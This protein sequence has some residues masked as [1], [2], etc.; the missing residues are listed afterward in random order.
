M[1][2][3]QEMED[4]MVARDQVEVSSCQLVVW[5]ELEEHALSLL[6][7]HISIASPVNRIQTESR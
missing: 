1:C 4:N 3:D 2:E 7:Q 5:Q 6:H